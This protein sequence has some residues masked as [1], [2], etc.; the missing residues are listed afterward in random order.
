[1]D[2]KPNWL[3][4]PVHPSLPA[5][6]N[7]I[8]AFALIFIIAVAT[9]FYNLGARVMSHDE[10]LHTYFSWLLYRGQ[11]YEHT[12]MMHG[13]LQFHLIAL[14]YFLFG[15][16]DFTARIPAVLFNLLTIG[17]V[18]HWRRYLGRAGAIIAGVL[19]VVS[20]F[21]LYYGRYVREDS[22]PIFSGILMLY[23]VLRHLESGGT[24]YLNLLALAL[25]IHFAAKETSFIYAAQLLIYLAVYFIAQVSR[26]SWK[27]AAGD[28]RAFILSL[29]VTILFAGAALGYALYA[30]TPQTLNPAEIAAPTNPE[31]APPAAA[32]HSPLTIILGIIAAS[33]FVATAYFLI[34]GYTWQ[35]LRSNRSFELLIVVGTIVLPQLSP[36]L[37]DLT[38][39][40]IPTTAPEIAALAGDTYAIIV[41]AV[42]LILAFA[43]A[44]V[45]GLIWNPKKWW[46]TAAIFWTPYIILY[47][48]IFTNP[49]GF[50]TGVIGSLGYW[51]VQHGVERGSQP[52]YYYLVVQVPVYEFLPALGLILALILGV[53]RRIR[54][55]QAYE[56]DIIDGS[57]DG[58][59]DAG[60][61]SAPSEKQ[62]ELFARKM[63]FVNAFSLLVWWSFATFFAFSFAGERMPWLTIHITLPLILITGW[64]LGSIVEQTNWAALK[65]KKAALGVAV[66][67]IFILGVANV[68]Y[69][70]NTAPFPFQ[71]SSLEQLQATN[72]FVLPL[73]VS[74]LSAVA[75][76]YLLRDWSLKDV[77]YVFTLVVFAFLG[78]L[79]VRASFRASYL[80]YDQ[81]TEYLVYAHGARGIKDVIEQATEI[82]K[83]TT[84]GMNVALAYD[85]SA[86]DTGV[87][88]PFVW[89]LRDFTNQQ[90]FDKP[91]RA[92]RDSVIVIVDEKNFGNIDQALGPGYY[93]EDYI[94]MWW[95]MQD[96]FNLV[97][98][99]DPNQPFDEN[100]PCTGLL[101]VFKLAKSKDYS[102]FCDGFTN[103][104]MRA[105]LFQIWLNRD[106][107][108]Y[109][110]IN[111][112]SDLDIATWQP[113]DLMRMY[114]RKDVAAQIWN[115][116]VAPSA[117]VQQSDPTEG[118]QITLSAN[119]ILGAN[120]ANPLTL[121]APRAL[122]FAPDG[123]LYIADSLNHRILHV[124]ADG[125]LLQSWGSFADGVSVPLGN[126]T[127][128]EPWGVA[129]GPDGSVY[130]SDTWN[131]RI[132][133]FT[134][135]GVFVKAWGTFGQGDTP[136][137]FY[138]PRGLAAD[139]AGR[140]YVADTGN[141]RI[142][143]FDSDG[144]FVTEFGGAGFDPGLFDEPTSVAVDRNGTVYVTDTWN[145]RVQTFA[146]VETEDGLTFVPQKQWDVFGWFGQSLNNKPY[147]AVNNQAHVFI[148]D[149]E[150]YRVIEFDADGQVV[151]VWG[152]YGDTDSTFGLASGIAVDPQGNVWVG[153]SAFNR[154]MRF[155]LP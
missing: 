116:G 51:I 17:M 133:K 105:A 145:Q 110:Q 75:S 132:E 8:V 7:E 93:R 117:G 36:L 78:I 10:S 94:R 9:R 83:R 155:T 66:V 5:I 112:R 38:N 134:S 81:A 131:S 21:M 139:S 79:T 65:E 103:P 34:R 108:L 98:S 32:P 86:P 70:L 114:I 152:D 149:P 37:I 44:I 58:D 56:E 57:F 92:L 64:A 154:I 55:P 144:N 43:A 87:S 3:D 62:Q 100:Y 90:A 71:G 113:A 53:R 54:L 28:Q 125:S 119:L 50:F 25:L 61:T 31:A 15:V 130:V 140:V 124:N 153:D 102:R 101:S 118:K 89:Y 60:W 85:A 45:V 6:T 142:V 122:A 151:R 127:F 143:V 69:A 115:Y 27:G 18:W 123:T 68:V 47:T 135:A 121:N 48:A 20:P 23:V 13:P 73:I 52:W 67:I 49:S 63:N 128:N 84:G 12:P 33:A 46:K 88:W 80:A 120:G 97:G 72:R 35:R 106:Y 39:V 148:T 104:Q 14:S 91:T 95:P 4:R 82:S 107:S 22:Y 40:T 19:L 26:A 11:G 126:G 147:I 41:I 16:S 141:K 96:Y 146:P 29:C 99:R 1:M 24:K 111:G 30:Q 136:D 138:G 77:R 129:V 109:A 59:S 42:C 150:G 76:V 2:S 137:A 74:I